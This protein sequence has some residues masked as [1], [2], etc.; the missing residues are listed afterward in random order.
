M[1][2]LPEA[3]PRSR[4]SSEVLA[5]SQHGSFC[6][7][8]DPP[9]QPRRKVGQAPRQHRRRRTAPDAGNVKSVT[10]PVVRGQKCPCNPVLSAWTTALSDI[11]SWGDPETG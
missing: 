1:S 4:A 9:R 7:R 3:V 11:P 5:V 6:R 8:Q 2:R 10:I